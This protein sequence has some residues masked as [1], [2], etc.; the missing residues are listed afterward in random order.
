MQ[1]QSAGFRAYRVVSYRYMTY[2]ELA[3]AMRSTPDRA[4]AL[5]VS[6]GWNRHID[7]TGRARVSVP[8]SFISSREF[9]M[10]GAVGR[11]AG[12]SL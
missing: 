5:A 8:D 10:L 1:V 4:S 7:R 3:A 9:S 6:S 11:E 12:V 2:D